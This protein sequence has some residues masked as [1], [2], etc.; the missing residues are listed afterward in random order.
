M[1]IKEFYSN[2]HSFDYSIPHFITYIRGIRI[3]ATPKLISN[4]LHVPRVSI[5][6]TS[7][8]LA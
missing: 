4:V 1:I 2:M 3:V 7:D 6:I 5:L 8:V